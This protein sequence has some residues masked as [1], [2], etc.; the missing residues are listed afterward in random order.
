[1]DSHL[2]VHNKPWQAMK[3]KGETYHPQKA[4]KAQGL[5]T[6]QCHPKRKEA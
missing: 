6:Q 4:K 2:R 3:E 1:M 5:F